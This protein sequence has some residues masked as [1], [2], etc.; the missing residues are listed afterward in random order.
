MRRKITAMGRG[1]PPGLG[2]VYY[3]GRLR[4]VPGI[5][6]P[7]LVAFLERLESAPPER[8]RAMLREAL[9]GGVQGRVVDGSGEDAETTALLDGLL[10]EF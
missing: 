6:P 1:R 7:A 10:E 8:K 2:K 3:L 9:T 4:A 5:D